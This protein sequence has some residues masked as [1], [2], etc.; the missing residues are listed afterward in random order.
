MNTLK[1]MIQ[2]YH[3]VFAASGFG[4]ALGAG[5][6]AMFL[7]RKS[8]KVAEMLF[9]PVTVIAAIIFCPLSAKVIIR[10]VG[11]TVWRIFWALPV[12]AV[13]AW[14]CTAVAT[15][16][17]KKWKNGLLGAVCIGLIALNGSML[18]NAENYSPR[19]NWYKLPQAVI[20]VADAINTHAAE[21]RIKKKRVLAPNDVVVCIREY[22]ASLMLK[23]GRGAAQNPEIQTPV[24]DQINAEFPDYTYL[25]EHSKKMR[26]MVV[27]KA[28]D[29]QP[30]IENGNFSKIYENDKYAVYFNLKYEK[31]KQ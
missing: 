19:E 11:D 16:Q 2:I 9:W 24:Y 31:K 28:S 3:N 25:T 15:S 13:L 8:D 20:E 12:V 26:Y 5:L 30:E 22:D 14:V 18:F 17:N 29:N 27:R 21:N 23:F 7:R 10:F 1:Y 6:I 4:L